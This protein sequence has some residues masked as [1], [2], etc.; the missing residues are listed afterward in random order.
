MIDQYK[1]P[2]FNSDQSQ[3]FENF[4]CDIFR[5]L[6]KD[7]GAQLNGRRWQPQHGIDIFGR[8]YRTNRRKPS[9]IGVQC[10][11]R[12]DKK[13]FYN[14]I[15]YEVKAA[16]KFKPP[17][18]YFWI[19]TTLSRDAGL[20]E[21]LNIFNEDRI[22]RGEFT[23]HIKSWE[24]LIHDATPEITYKYY[25]S[26]PFTFPFREFNEYIRVPTHKHLDYT[27]FERGLYFKNQECHESIDRVFS[28]GNKCLLLGKPASGKTS[29]ALGYTYAFLQELHED[30]RERQAFYV[31][32]R[33][34][35]DV[36]QWIR[37]MEYYDYGHC[38][39]II[40]N[41]HLA[42]EEINHL[43]SRWEGILYARI[44][45]VSRVI[46]E[47]LAGDSTENY[48][49][50][51]RGKTGEEEEKEENRTVTVDANKTTEEGIISLYSKEFNKTPGEIGSIEEIAGKTGRNLMVLRLYIETW[52][53]KG[54]LVLSEIDESTILND[55][56]SFY[57]KR[58]ETR[59]AF[60]KIAALSQFEIKTQQ[61]FVKDMPEDTE[62]LL[63]IITEE[64]KIPTKFYTHH[65]S[66]IAGYVL[67]AALNQGE[68]NA[69][70]DEYTF[71]V[72][73]DYIRSEPV[74]FFEILKNLYI[75]EELDLQ[76][77]IFKQP[78]F[79]MRWLQILYQAGV[80]K[81]AIREFCEGLNFREL[82]ERSKDIGLATTE[83]FI[84]I[85][86]QSGVEIKKLYD[87]CSGLDFF[88]LGEKFISQNSEGKEIQT[89]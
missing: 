22:A 63:D 86:Y 6:W 7:P 33:W 45:L 69:S 12:S 70:V 73:M 38:F 2:K 82:G 41:C 19:A 3:Q 64:Y 67:Q 26:P 31:D 72:I 46:Q 51:M 77:K 58:K 57:L 17:I 20:Q 9:F 27:D 48:L 28:K 5:I 80:E 36:Y 54:D 55:I 13:G 62:G 84:K 59:E 60:L 40:D 18:Q 61:Q 75:N 34:G 30:G 44:L 37:Q 14:K 21:Q 65:H 88:L 79:I 49:L 15:L 4:C 50:L 68:L 89:S 42:V 8:D 43:V 74:N 32:A 81:G 24:D 11:I 23:V 47:D 25:K 29:L 87:F 1:F 66:V 85:L 78:E 35:V 76:R 71:N 10:K 16:E 53:K 52:H 39:F 83:K 56:Y